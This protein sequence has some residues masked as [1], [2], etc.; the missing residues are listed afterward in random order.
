MSTSPSKI[1]ETWIDKYNAKEEN[2]IPVDYK[3]TRAARVYDLYVRQGLDM[4]A[5]WSETC[6]E[7]GINPWLSIRMNDVHFN[8]EQTVLVKSS[9]V[10]KYSKE[11]ISAHRTPMAYF[12][13]KTEYTMEIQKLYPE[14]KDYIWGGEKLKIKYGKQTNKTPCAESWELSFHKD[15]L[16]QLANGTDC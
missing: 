15:G 1:L 2:G 7:I 11:W 5:I 14:C 3:A 10:E 12:D 16:T 8:M 4:Y 9:Q 13:K 6:K